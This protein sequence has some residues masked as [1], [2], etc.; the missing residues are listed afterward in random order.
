M[1]GARMRDYFVSRRVSSES[2]HIIENW[3]DGTAIRPR[4]AAASELRTRLGLQNSFVACYSGNLGRAHEYDTILGAAHALRDRSD[5]VFLMI[6]GG[7]KMD[8][9]RRSVAESGLTN[10]RFE[11]YQPREALADSL[12][13]ADVH[14]TSLLPELEGLIVP[15]KIYRILAAGRPAIFIGD[16][17]AG[18]CQPHP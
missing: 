10:F 16:P 9:L 8:A 2:L 13:A 15:S 1:L 17:A 12:S 4:S 3:A 18:T 5:F 14:L 6:G 11:R 7:A